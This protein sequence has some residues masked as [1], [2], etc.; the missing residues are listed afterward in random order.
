M[1]FVRTRGVVKQRS[2][3]GFAIFRTAQAE[4]TA[5]RRIDCLLK[6]SRSALVIAAFI[7][8]AKIYFEEGTDNVDP[9]GL[10]QAQTEQFRKPRFPGDLGV[11]AKTRTSLRPHEQR[12]GG[13]VE[14]A[15]IDS[16]EGLVSDRGITGG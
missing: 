5:D 16:A 12:I 7:V 9:D 6:G 11:R 2:L 10:R 14:L 4:Q 8:F 3:Y 1:R 15:F 13:R